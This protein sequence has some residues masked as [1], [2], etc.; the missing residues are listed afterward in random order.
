MRDDE[1]DDE[2]ARTVESSEAQDQTSDIQA[3]AAASEDSFDV[4]FDP[5]VELTPPP[6]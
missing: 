4:D 6:R 3:A 1:R 2:N 5:P